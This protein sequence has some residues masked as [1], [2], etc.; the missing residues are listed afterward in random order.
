[1]KDAMHLVMNVVAEKYC[2]KFSNMCHLALY[3]GKEYRIVLPKI[4]FISISVWPQ[5]SCL[6]FVNTGFLR[7][8]L[9]ESLMMTVSHLPGSNSLPPSTVIQLRST[10][11]TKNIIIVPEKRNEMEKSIQIFMS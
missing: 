9:D 4:L 3:L 11:T 8:K 6:S 5:A 10:P 2:K 1:M 7:R